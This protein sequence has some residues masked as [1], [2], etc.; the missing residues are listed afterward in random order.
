VSIKKGAFIEKVDEIKKNFPKLRPEEAMQ[1]ARKDFPDEFQA[2][3][4]ED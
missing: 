4:A 3:Q 1:K 2:Y